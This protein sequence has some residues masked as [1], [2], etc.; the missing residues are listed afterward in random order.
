[1][2]TPLTFCISIIQIDILLNVLFMWNVDASHVFPSLNVSAGAGRPTS[3]TVFI[4][5]LISFGGTASWN[6]R[7]HVCPP[8]IYSF[9]T[10]ILLSGVY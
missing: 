10:I 9:I 8:G 7:L 3:A 5:G 6:I 1:M 2:L 4:G